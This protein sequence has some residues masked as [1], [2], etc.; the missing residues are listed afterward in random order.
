MILERRSCYLFFISSS[1]RLIGIGIFNT[2]FNIYF[3]DSGFQESFLGIFLAIGNI[4]MAISSY[5]IGIIID[6]FPK[7][8]LM[9]LFTIG[10]CLCYFFQT[11]IINKFLLLIIS[12]VFG[13]SFIG[14]INLTGPYLYSFK[15]IKSMFNLFSIYKFINIISTTIGSV[16]AGFCF[17]N[18]MPLRTILYL[19]TVFVLLSVVPQLF[20]E[21]TKYDADNTGLPCRSNLD[22]DRFIFTG[23]N[24]T[25]IVVL[26]FSFLIIG[27][28]PML[29][30]Y[31]N[32]F[33]RLKT[34]IS[35]EN[36][37][38]GQASIHLISGS[39][40]LFFAKHKIKESSLTKNIIFFII[41][42]N[43]FFIFIYISSSF[44]IIIS[45]FIGLIWTFEILFSLL[46]DFIFSTTENKDHGKF[47]GLINFVSNFSETAG[48]LLCGYLIQN[49]NY[50]GI[51]IYS[52]L[53][54]ILIIPILILFSKK[55]GY[56]SNGKLLS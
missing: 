56:N 45:C 37:A 29:I 18:S 32:L 35:V 30:N 34:G 3:I 54:T 44:I 52:I 48:I 15:T 47:S 26:F 24:I 43:L 7:K 39:L 20:L 27:F 50:I 22:T 55:L 16:I 21:D 5:P 9:T 12:F 10:L 2:L 46:N 11:I 17:N 38:F 33:L 13:I 14:L 8:N 31:M 4:S 23:K 1:I 41:L 40:I 53:P 36:I 6:K 49:K 51:Y 42:S 28:S 25:V 19:S